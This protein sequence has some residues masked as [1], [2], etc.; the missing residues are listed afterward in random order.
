M[1]RMPSIYAIVNAVMVHLTDDQLFEITI[2]AKTQSSLL[3]GK[4]VI[5]CVN[6]DASDLVLRAKAGLTVR[7]MDPVGLADACRQLYYM[8][9]AEREAMGL[10]GRAYYFQN[11]SPEVQIDKYEELFENII[12]INKG[13]CC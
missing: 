11:L 6:G 8:T 5:A 2:P 12:L 10:A 1:E 4:P 7:A 3:S 9:P 13:G